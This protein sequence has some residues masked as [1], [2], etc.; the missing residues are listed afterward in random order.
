[1]FTVR[2]MPEQVSRAA[3]DAL[4]ACE[5][6]TIG[7]F[8]HSQFMDP[9]IRAVIPDRRAAG[10]AVTALVPGM[11]GTMMHWAVGHARPGDF[12]VVDRAGDARHACWGGVVT[13]AAREAGVVGAAIDGYG[14]DFPEVR[15]QGLPLWCRGPSPI[16]TKVLGLE[17]AFNVPVS[18]GGV[19]VHPGD[20]ILA[21]ESGVVVLRPSQVDWVVAE[22]MR[23]QNLEPDRVRRLRAGEKLHVV[24]GAGARVEAALAK[25]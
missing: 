10:T 4:R 9:A 5:T 7:H 8:L 19:T 2:P 21:D 18:C 17:G 1:M 25:E 6:A 23:R 12:L 24:S 16:T 22:A 13:I 3:L 20:A 11:D 14:T 15:E